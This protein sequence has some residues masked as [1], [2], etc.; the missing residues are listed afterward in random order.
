MLSTVTALVASLAASEADDERGPGELVTRAQDLIAAAIERGD[1]P[2]SVGAIARELYVS[3]SRLCDVFA[4]ETGMGI[5]AYARRLRLERA[6]LLLANERLSIA[7]VAGLLGYPSPSAFC[8]AFASA[9]G[10]SPRAWRRSYTS[11]RG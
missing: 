10:R 6:C 1:E 11:Q 4:R 8:H 5:G 9:M 3:R 7:E 2:P